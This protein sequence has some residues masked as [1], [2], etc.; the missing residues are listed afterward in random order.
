[1]T[2]RSVKKGTEDGKDYS[3]DYRFTRVYVKQNGH[4]MTIALRT[5]L[6]HQ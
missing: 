2:G 4:W 6:I 1:V 3:G 5:T